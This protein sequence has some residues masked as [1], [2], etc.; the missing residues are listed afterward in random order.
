LAIGE[1]QAAG[2]YQAYG[3]PHYGFIAARADYVRRMP[4]RIVGET[5][6]VE[7]RRAYVLTLQT[8]EQHIRREKATS[9]ITTNQTL[10][11]LAGLVHLS[12]LGPQGLHEVGETCMALAAYAKERLGLPLLFPDQTTFKEFAIRVG[13]PADAAIRAAREHGVHPGYA[14]KRD[15]AGMEDAL[16]VCVTERRTPADIERLAEALA[17]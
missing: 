4:G 9:N 10:L 1:G 15:Y 13:R 12:W 7:G 3:G 2:N 16:L 8:R 11:A 6:D 17:A 14:L 5:T